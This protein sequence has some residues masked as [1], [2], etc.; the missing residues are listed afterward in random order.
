M[1]KDLEYILNQIQK[2]QDVNNKSLQKSIRYGL[3]GIRQYVDANAETINIKIDGITSRQDRQ[4]DA[5]AKHEK[6]IGEHEKFHRAYAF[7]TN[8]PLLSF[9]IILIIGFGFNWVYH[10]I[11]IRKT[12]ENSTGI[13]IEDDAVRGEPYVIS[14]STYYTN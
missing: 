2:N 9:F 3:K 5:M 7:F 4:N 14:D 11:N 1:D 12:L 13:V 10:R 8:K 6:K